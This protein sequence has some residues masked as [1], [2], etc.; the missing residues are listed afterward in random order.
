MMRKKVATI[1]TV[2]ALLV[3]A[4]PAAF[5]YNQYSIGCVIDG[6][7]MNFTDAKPYID[8]NNRTMIPL[9]SISEYMKCTVDWDAATQSVT[10]KDTVKNCQYIYTIGSRE[11]V[12]SRVPYMNA[13]DT[14]PAIKNGRTYL[15]VRFIGE[16]FGNVEWRDYTVYITTTEE[17]Q[18]AWR[19]DKELQAKLAQGKTVKVNDVMTGM[20]EGS[21]TSHGI[22]ML[23]ECEDAGEL[24]VKL[25]D[26]DPFG[27][28][29]TELDWEGI[30]PFIQ[31][32]IKDESFIAYF[33]KDKQAYV[34]NTPLIGST[35]TIA[36]LPHYSFAASTVGFDH[37]GIMVTNP[38][39]KSSTLYVFP[40]S[41][42]QE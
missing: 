26:S 7:H 28:Y 25:L 6:K 18:P 30:K 34:Y 13:M 35:G 27:C 39:G 33:I 32:S 8:E 29:Y 24:T 40:L 41:M 5:A 14:T 21:Q 19:N 17:Y 12:D 15:P 23:K 16:M 2:L 42:D 20:L 31:T 9:R 36:Y 10:V 4:V 22:G 1:L 37:L 38:D 3:F 11:F